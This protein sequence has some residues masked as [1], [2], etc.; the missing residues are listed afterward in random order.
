MGKASFMEAEKGENYRP[1]NDQLLRRFQGWRSAQGISIKQAATMLNRSE[2]QVEDYLNFNFRGDL[3]RFERDIE[4]L[5]RLKD[6]RIFVGQENFLELSTSHEILKVFQFC[7][8]HKQMGAILGPAGVSKT[9]TARAFARKNPG[10][11]LV[12]ASLDRKSVS[13]VVTMLSGLESCGF[14][15]A[16]TSELLERIVERLRYSEELLIID[17]SHFLSWEGFEIV[18]TLWDRAQTGIVYLAG[19]TLYAEMKKRSNFQWDQILSRLAMRKNLD[20]ILYS[21]IELLADSLYPGL[22]KDC[23]TFL[24][25]KGLENG[26]FRTVALLLKQLRFIASTEHVEPSLKLLKQI[27]KY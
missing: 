19:P 26:R 11:L 12:T 3:E 20:K 18:R 4:N 23:L 13:S 22:E 14:W 5:L 15:G 7:R 2:S 25:E 21:D 6:Q 8:T 27:A 10:T 9:L 1:Y 24:F 17:E 16:R